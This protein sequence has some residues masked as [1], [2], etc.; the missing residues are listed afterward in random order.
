MDPVEEILQF[1]QGPLALQF[2]LVPKAIEMAK[3]CSNYRVFA[4]LEPVRAGFTDPLSA[5]AMLGIAARQLAKP[6]ED[7]QPGC[8]DQ[9]ARVD[10]QEPGRIVDAQLGQMAGFPNQCQRVD[11]DVGTQ[12]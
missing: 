6:V 10:G 1:Q 4:V 12:I 5:G 3:V 2:E 11:D 9:A 7:L 8:G